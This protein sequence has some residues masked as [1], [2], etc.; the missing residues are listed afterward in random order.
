MDLHPR[1]QRV[2]RAVS[3]AEASPLRTAL[4]RIVT[5]VGVATGLWL[6][7]GTAAHADETSFW[8]FAPVLPAGGS[9]SGDAVG[10][11]P[12]FSLDT[13][14]TAENLGAGAFSSLAAFTRFTSQEFPAVPV[15]PPDPRV[16]TGGAGLPALSFASVGATAEYLSTAHSVMSLMG[17]ITGSPERESLLAPLGLADV[18]HPLV[19]K[20]PVRQAL[21]PVTKVAHGVVIRPVDRSLDEEFTTSLADPLSGRSAL[22]HTAVPRGTASTIPPVA[23]V[24]KGD[25][26]TPHRVSLHATT[27]R[28]APATGIVQ[29]VEGLPSTPSAPLPLP[30]G[31]AF[32][33]LGAAT[34]GG[35]SGSSA[36]PDHPNTGP[37]EMAGFLSQP[38]ISQISPATTD[39]GAPRDRAEDPVVSPD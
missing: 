7:A 20:V 14:S 9:H 19:V 5:L 1:S 34:S 25:V 23:K 6:L 39:A 16:A 21:R 26:G 32:P 30:G 29:P 35:A 24:A 37:V 13:E 3:R 28:L 8:S 33:A 36:T 2:E 10:P 11:L 15:F 22:H 18:V 31:L 27:P 12:G 4:A 17:Q 38:L